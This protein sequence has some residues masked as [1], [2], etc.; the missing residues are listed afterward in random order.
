MRKTIL[1][2]LAITGLIT[3]N[4]V[5][6]H[7]QSN[8][9]AIVNPNTY[10]DLKWR[11][12]GPHRG[13]R[14]TAA[15][16]VRTQPNV[17]YF[18]ATGGGV[19]KTDNYGITW[20]P[21]SDGQI[22]TGSIGAID[23]ADSNPNVIYVGTGSEAIRSNVILGRGVYKS[24]DAGRTWQFVGLHDVG[25]IGQ[26][27]IHPKNP[28]IAYVAAVGNPFA[29]GPERGVYRTRDGGKTWQKVLSINDQTG[30][31]SIAI[32]WQNPN[33]LYAGAW[34]AQRKPW[35]IIS[36]GPASEG[37]VYKTTDGGDHWSRM[38]NG[39]PDDLIG[40]V[41]VDIAQSNPKVVYA[42]VE[43]KGAKGGL[44]RSDDGG[45]KWTIVNSTQ[46]LRARPF[47]FNKVF[48]NPKDENEVWV[49]ELG[50]HKSTDGGKTFTTVADPHG[51]NHIVWFNADNPKVMIET[52]D[53]GANITQDGGRSWS[54]QNNQ[55]TAEMYHV[56]ADEQ[57]PYLIYGP[58]QD[59]GKNLAVPQFPPTA[60][61]PDDPRQLWIP[62]PGCESGQVRP[63][64]SGKIVYGDCKGEFGRMNMATGQEQN[65]WIN[66]QQRYGK[67]PQNMMYRFVRQSPIEIDAHNPNIVYHGS[68]YVHKS[69][70]G[71][72]HWTKFSPDVTANGPEGHVTSGEPITR[73]M[74]G[75]EV[76]AALY[77]MRSS[78]LEP[79]VFW[80]GSNDGPVWVTKDNGAHWK[81]VTP[82]MPPGGRVHTI[83]DS[84][85][86][87]GSAYV[88][89]YRMYENDFKP[90]AY[91]TNDYGE[92]WTLLTDGNNG[93]PADQPMHV[94]REDPE[95]EGLLY[96]GTLEGAYVSF[97]QG[98]HWQSLQLNLPNTPVTDIKVHHGD[99]VIATMGR[100]FWIMDDVAP[101]RQIAAS[102]NK[103]Q[104]PTSTANDGQDGRERQE[105]RDV[106]RVSMQTPAAKSDDGAKSG[107]AQAFRLAPI[108]PFD[109]AS[110]FLF[111]PAPAYRVHYNASQGRPDWP[112][113]PAAGAR[114]DYFLANPSGDVKLEILD[115]AGKVVR[116]YTNA[117]R[118]APAGGRGG[119][120][121]GGGLPSTLPTK[122]G[123]NRFVWDLRYPG[124]PAGAGDGEGGGFG[125]NGPLVA[126]GTYRARLTAN[127]V[128][129]TEAFTVKIDPR[130]AK[131]GITTADLQAQTTFQ[132]KVRDLLA[133]ARQLSARLRQ[134]IDA[135]KGNESA[136]QAVQARLV[137][138]SGPYEDQM[139]I[140]QVSNIGREMGQADQKVPASAI[141]RFAQLQKEWTSIKAD[142][143]KALQ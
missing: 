38:G 8:A 70:D 132:L 97:D 101:L 30:V 32:N 5:R 71:G 11:S 14:S 105:R 83:E 58:Q 47:Y 102:M 48:A 95:Q 45:A 92:H 53:G 85:H 27:K 143:E 55:P 131:D 46:A 44:Y 37:G 1:F 19:W 33:E 134:A 63:I 138:K 141:E 20:M 117:V 115:T 130:I 9:N 3:V 25:Q 99:L 73:D 137:T 89:I 106:V 128:T 23:V 62:L 31:V 49:T 80:T 114:I 119:G 110:V 116:E 72:V 142:A 140:D 40:K 91:M 50:L 36:G 113:Y 135:K 79:G 125:G 12:V 68:Q 120:R 60:W 16:G 103:R 18:G 24:T 109:N 118:A 35:T 69:I 56:D 108:K 122:V 29:W 43:A 7:A 65:Y 98:K 86:R 66:P 76:Y 87:K 93:I 136:L 57:F 94:V 51:D 61:G 112:E 139:F 96:A 28:D 81:N 15:V 82:P 26:L 67:E 133:D 124:G 4:Q 6:D 107:V 10:Q 75:E 41:W 2:A 111:T 64:P 39:L 77:S 78:R 17:F 126:P 52:N 74:T 54:T 34:R 21:V 59:T 90:Y 129:K 100:S 42:Q 121:R 123:M 127:G 84:P 88:S 22:P 13:G 104:R